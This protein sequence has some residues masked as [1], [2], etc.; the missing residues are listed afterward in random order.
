MKR[1]STCNRTYDDPNLSFCIDDGT[2]LRLVE[3]ED[4]DT[5]VVRPR[6]TEGQDWNAVAYQPPGSYVPPGSTEVKRRR[7]WPWVVGIGG[8]FVLGIL[9]LAVAGVILLPRMMRSAQERADREATRQGENSN[10]NANANVN[11]H[12]ETNSNSNSN[13]NQS[14]D[15]PPPADHDQVLG[16]LTNLEQEW[17]VANVSA[18]K[19]KLDHILADDFV[20]QG[21]Q[22]EPQTKADYIRTIQRDTVIDKWEFSD[23]KLN[24]AGDRATLNGIFTYFSDERTVSYDFED[25]FVWRDGRWQATGSALKRRGSPDEDL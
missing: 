17:T 22:G 25:K 10:A 13:A 19:K 8:A 20:G 18:D 9:A 21:E 4:D 2:P 15:T 24:L 14:V 3:T 16:Q 1:C 5:T 23:L 7:A 11:G 6:D 12:T